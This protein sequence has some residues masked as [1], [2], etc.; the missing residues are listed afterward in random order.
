MLPLASC[1]D[2]GVEEELATK[3][4]DIN[5]YVRSL[6][7]DPDEL[8]QVQETGPES[9]VRTLMQSVEESNKREGGFNISCVK[10]EF[11]LK[12]NFEEVAVLRPTN[13]VIFPGAIVIGDAEM[14]DGAPTPLQVNR[15]PVSLRIDLPGIGENGNLIVEDPNN[16]AV[17]AKIDE[18][19]EWWNENAYQEGYVNP[20]YISYNT[21]T[22]YSSQQLSIDVG[23][24]VA[25]A[26][27]DVA[28]QFNF[29]SST[30]KSVAMMA[31]KQGFYSVTMEVPEQPSDIFDE[32]VTLADIERKITPGAPPAYVHSVV[33][34]RIIMFRMESTSNV[35]S[36]DMKLALEFA[37]GV[38][39]VSGDTEVRVRN[40]L[41]NASTTVVTIGGNAEVASEAVSATNFGD[42]Q[43]IIQ[44]PN[45]VYNR[46]NPGVPISY[47]IRYLKD[48]RLAKMGYTTDYS[49]TNCSQSL[50][51]GAKISVQ[52]DAGYLIRF[53]VRYKDK[54]NK[55]QMPYSS[56]EY[57]AGFVREFTLPDGAHD[58]TLD[59]DLRGVFDWFNFFEK[60]Y[61]T[62]AERKCYKTFGTLFDK[63]YAEITCN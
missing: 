6:S 23:L 18:A 24:N 11:N 47:T 25:W 49:V 38:A 16:G 34:G 41:A 22:S 10:D 7:Y 50:V 42:L 43:K 35:S 2:D 53:F 28:S 46:S 26:T 51:P 31:F 27:G 37:T 17:Q 59:V 1:M 44:G 21:S 36:T 56:G 32:N 15:A 40:I 45:A 55:P 8:L 5:E 57:S 29:Q 4:M 3:A 52:N 30:E 62:P 60:S 19:L 54:N 14:L 61:D 33:Y 20:A 13:G 12:S 48:N 63:R 39:T 9:T 58:I